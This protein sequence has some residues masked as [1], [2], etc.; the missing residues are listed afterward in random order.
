[1]LE[2]QPRGWKWQNVSIDKAI[3]TFRQLTTAGR[4]RIISLTYEAKGCHNHQCKHGSFELDTCNLA[5][6][7]GESALDP[8]NR[9]LL[10][11]IDFDGFERV[12]RY[13][14]HH[15]RKMGYFRDFLFTTQT[16]SPQRG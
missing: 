3:D 1:M 16:C 10:S 7:A 5:S 12:I 9:Q 6:F 11:E 15:P 14:M 13:M 2:V 8:A 4:Y